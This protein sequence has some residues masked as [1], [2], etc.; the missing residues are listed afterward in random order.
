MDEKFKSIEDKLDKIDSRLDKVDVHLAVYNSQLKDHIRRTELLEQ[1]IK[2]IKSH[3]ALMN[4]V[5]KILI[6]LS[7]L[8]GIIKNM[9][10]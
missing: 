2:P 9:R 1:E 3:V 10:S 6:F 8:V 7:I 5:A 4:S